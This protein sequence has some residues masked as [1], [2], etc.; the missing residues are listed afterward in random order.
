ML[1]SPE[2]GRLRASYRLL[3]SLRFAIVSVILFVSACITAQG[4]SLS[5]SLSAPSGS[6]VDEVVLID[7]RQSVGVSKLLQTDGRPSVVI[8]FGDGFSANLL[9]SG[10]AYRMPGTY[11]I[12]L[13]AKDSGGGTAT[14]QRT[15]VVSSIPPATGSNV[16][17]LNDTGDP[18]LNGANLQVAI[19][20]AAAS[21]ST[22]EQEIVLPAGAVFAGEIIL[23]TPVGD[24]Y[25][26]IRSG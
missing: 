7:A 14:T 3:V 11:T 17:V 26:T 19:N 21:N 16:R 25:I 23:P 13:T 2:L 18:V 15:I 22:A 4:Q 24:K 1:S 12:T 5:V 20:A 8:D 10:H 6:Y 9:A